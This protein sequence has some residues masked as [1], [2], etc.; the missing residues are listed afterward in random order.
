MRMLREPRHDVAVVHPPAVRTGEILPDVVPLERG[1]GAEPR[2]PLRV[3]VD[4]VHAEQER[5]E[6]LPLVTEGHDA[7]HGIGHASSIVQPPSA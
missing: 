5:I 6:R 7:K 2:V 3:V 4:M 1:V